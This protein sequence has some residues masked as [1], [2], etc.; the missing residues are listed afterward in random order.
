ML[1]DVEQ[2]HYNE[3]H[4]NSIYKALGSGQCHFIIYVTMLKIIMK[5]PGF[6]MTQQLNIEIQPFIS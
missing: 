4:G 6:E 1:I 2:D 3:L 5:F